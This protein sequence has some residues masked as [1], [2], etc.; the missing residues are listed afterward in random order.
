MTRLFM[1]GLVV[2]AMVLG[3]ASGAAA[4]D[5][6]K[7]K[8]MTVPL[9][10]ELPDRPAGAIT[11]GKIFLN[12]CPGGCTV[13][14]GMDDATTD[15]SSL[16]TQVKNLP[17]YTGFAAGEWAQV[18]Q[19]V[20]EVY[21]P[22]AVVVTDQ[23]PPSTDSYAEIMIGGSPQDIGLPMGVGGVA[24]IVPGCGANPKGVSFAF[25]SAINVFAA[26]AG[27]SRV[28]GLCWI[29]AQETAHN[30]IGGGHAYEFIEDG[31]SA[32]ND[33]MTYRADCGGQKFF[34]NKVARE[35]DFAPCGMPDGQSNN[36]C[37]C[38]GQRNAHQKMVEVFGAGQT[39]IAP[40]TVNINF[41]APGAALGATVTGLAG[42][43]RGVERVEMYLNG[44]KWDT[45]PGA[46]F[47]RTGQAN[48]SSYQF[49]VP[50]N[51][52]NSTYDIVLKAYDDL[53]AN[54][55]SAMVTVN[56]GG[57]CAN[58]E[59]CAKGQKCEN[60]RCFW[61]QP[62]AEIGADCT[63]NEFCTSLMCQGTAE[64]QICTQKCIPGTTDSCPSESGLECRET[65]PG[66][67]ICFIP[68][69]SGG[70]CSVGHD[71]NAWIPGAFGALVFGAIVLRP[72]RRK[73]RA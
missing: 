62:T 56:K 72:R 21:S 46:A 64:Q 12:L 23:R 49:A 37:L 4:E 42:S 68:E 45:K 43:K 48:P 69:D 25:T 7:L 67:G 27:G 22:Y 40:P 52:P 17:E 34:R 70:C 33:P 28:H 9:P 18:L 57:P 20:K 36:P 61:E 65:G 3:G 51:L 31:R 58:A 55:S 13:R 73:Q 16:V 1:S 11:S 44:W 2:S 26:E 32:C 60:G 19:C 24:S 39:T 50:G 15:T 63:Y 8:L 41:P 30:F 54:T 29:I 6:S 53:G 35:G 71:S 5:E 10:Y 38:G 59:S 66:M 47:A 14:P